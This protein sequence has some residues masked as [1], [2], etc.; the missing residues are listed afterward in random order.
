VDVGTIFQGGLSTRE[1]MCEAFIYYYPKSSL[2]DCRSQPEY[3]AYLDALGGVKNATG[4]FL[5]RLNIPYDP[6]LLPAYVPLPLPSHLNIIKKKRYYS[7][8]L[9]LFATN[10]EKQDLA[11]ADD[12]YILQFAKERNLFSGLRIK[13]PDHLN[14]ENL[15]PYMSSLNWRDRAF[16]KSVEEKFRQAPRYMHCGGDHGDRM[17]IPVRV[18][19]FL[20]PLQKFLLFIYFVFYVSETHCQNWGL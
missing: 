11:L 5:R 4:S 20:P 15:F 17:R 1:E 16:A 3:Y 9:V 8:S 2:I 19:S 14:G 6:A 7:L 13:K 10:R 12:V 18:I